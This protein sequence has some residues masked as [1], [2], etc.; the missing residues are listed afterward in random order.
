MNNEYNELPTNNELNESLNA[1]GY[2][3]DMDDLKTW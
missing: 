3:I 1:L 2:G